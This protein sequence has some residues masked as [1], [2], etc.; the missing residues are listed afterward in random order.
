MARV[1]ARVVIMP[2]GFGVR[3]NRIYTVYK[4]YIFI[5]KSAENCLTTVFDTYIILA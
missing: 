3:I 1:V 2:Y 5:Y 4:N